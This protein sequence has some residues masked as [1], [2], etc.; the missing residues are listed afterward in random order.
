M[1]LRRFSDAKILD[2]DRAVILVETPF[3]DA[4]TDKTVTKQVT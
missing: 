3:L 4:H 2:G 1:R